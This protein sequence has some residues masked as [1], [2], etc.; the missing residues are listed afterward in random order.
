MSDFGLHHTPG[1]A[2][3]SNEIIVN[4]GRARGHE[5]SVFHYDSQLRLLEGN[6]DYLITSNL[7]VIYSRYGRIID[8]IC[9]FKKHARLEHD[10]NM[11]LS[12]EDR[13]KLWTSCS[14]A[15]FLSE[16]HHERFIESY[17]DYFVNVRIVPDPID[18]SFRDFGQERRDVTLYAGFMHPLKGTSEFLRY[19]DQNPDED[20]IAAVWGSEE[21]LTE[22]RK[23]P[24]ID[25]IGVVKYEDM[26]NLYNSVSRMYYTPVCYEPFCRSVGEAIMCGV[27]QLICNNKIGSLD[28]YLKDRDGFSNKCINAA[29]TF[30]ETIENDFNTVSN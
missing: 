25:F 21:Y 23:R 13:R 15:F 10:M 5:I 17:G 20:F 6:Y 11:Y 29:K 19:V 14:L 9:Q 28:M 1:G 16:F 4:A 8:F 12:K 26:P 30:W 27:K 24:N 18:A 7:E 3:R 2:Q 22:I